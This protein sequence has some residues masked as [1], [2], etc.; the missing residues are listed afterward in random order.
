[1]YNELAP[2]GSLTMMKWIKLPLKKGS[3]G[4]ALCLSYSSFNAI[5]YTYLPELQT[6]SEID[7]NT[8]PGEIYLRAA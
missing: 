2:F 5:T 4:T 3:P 6:Q 8:S 7:A 1:M